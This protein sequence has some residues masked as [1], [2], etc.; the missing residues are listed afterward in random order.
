[1]Y[2]QINLY[3]PVFRQQSK[4]FS[5]LTL[6]QIFVVVT[7]LLLGLYGHA[8]WTLAGMN[9]TSASLEMKYL[10]LDTQLGVIE[11][12]RALATPSSLEKEIDQLQNTI[13]ERQELLGRLDQ[14]AIE[15]SP[16]FG[17]FF[18]RLTRHIQ[19][20]LWIT[21]IRLT[22]DGTTEL[23]GTTLKPALV[24]EYLQQMPDLPRFKSLQLGSV[25]LDR[26]EPGEPEIDF[27]LRSKGQ[28]HS[29]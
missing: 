3:Q 27:I 16:G 9:K 11:S 5:A 13:A 25:H 12:K 2:Q 26:P 8:R 18:M 28:E 6:L 1:M 15:T 29:L 19:P 24:P 23:R 20:G 7:I 21:G 17:E 22:D 4:V 10:Q 14:L